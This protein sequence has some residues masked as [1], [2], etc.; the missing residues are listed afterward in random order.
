MFIAETSNLPSRTMDEACVGRPV[1]DEIDGDAIGGNLAP[2]QRRCKRVVTEQCLQSLHGGYCYRWIGGVPC[3]WKLSM[4]LRPQAWPF[5]RSVSAQVS[6]R[7]GRIWD[8]DA[9]AAVSPFGVR[10]CHRLA[11]CFD[12]F[13]PSSGHRDRPLSLPLYVRAPSPLSC[14]A[15]PQVRRATKSRQPRSAALCQFRK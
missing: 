14:V 5:L 8:A 4:V 1:V 15:Y 9:A 7:V 2:P 6:T 11:S 12:C 13:Y 10:L 3:V